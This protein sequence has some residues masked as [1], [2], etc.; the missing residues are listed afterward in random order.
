MLR[1]QPGLFLQRTRPNVWI[2]PRTSSS[3]RC[4]ERGIH[5]YTTDEDELIRKRVSEGI[6]F[7]DIAG[8]LGVS[9]GSVHHRWRNHLNLALT[10]RKFFTKEEDD[11]MIRRRLEGVKHK[12]IAKE[13]GRSPGVVRHRLAMVAASGRSELPLL[14]GLS[15]DMVEDLITRRK[16]DGVTHA[17]IAVELKCPLT[18]VTGRVRRMYAREGFVRGDKRLLRTRTDPLDEKEV[19]HIA[20]RWEEKATL[21][22]IASE[23]GRPIFTLRKAIRTSQ[24]LQHILRIDRKFSPSEDS[25]IIALRNA[26][27]TYEQIAKELGRV[28]GSV[29]GRFRRLS[30]PRSPAS[31]RLWSAADTIKALK[32]HDAGQPMERIALE[33][34]RSLDS[35]RA[36]LYRELDLRGRSMDGLSPEAQKERRRLFAAKEKSDESAAMADHEQPPHS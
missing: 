19:R 25:K 35:V 7:A 27:N 16:A 32:L 8:E 24:E 26:G 31:R 36:R 28:Q 30:R 22:A 23:L 9:Q 21:K 20:R 18:T 5:S 17:S 3:G 6:T 13:L 11:I 4:C 14:N 33:V 10:P 34:D 15:A 1:R 12:D 29:R 2:P